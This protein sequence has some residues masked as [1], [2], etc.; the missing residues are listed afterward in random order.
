MIRNCI[1]VFVFGFMILQSS[2]S[3][4]QICFDVGS[5]SI[6]SCSGK[7][8]QFEIFEGSEVYFIKWANPN[9]PPPTEVNLRNIPQGYIILKGWKQE[10]IKNNY[11][12]LKPS[13]DYRIEKTGGDASSYRIT[14][15]IDSFGRVVKSS[16]E[17]CR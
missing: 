14:I 12:T 4:N 5:Q 3:N 11:I 9:I 13:F 16:Q 2:C 8:Y 6:I 1:L 17:N 10:R 15:H 7:L